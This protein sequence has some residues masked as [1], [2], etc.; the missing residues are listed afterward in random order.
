MQLP[1]ISQVV[2]ETRPMEAVAS[3]PMLPTMP[4]SMYCIAMDVS[5]ARIAGRLMPRTR[6]I[7]S[8]LLTSFLL[9]ITSMLLS[10]ILHPA[11]VRRVLSR[12]TP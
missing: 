5:C 4:A 8:A 9:S 3:A 11:S 6:R 1:P 10:F 7:F 12:R 2:D